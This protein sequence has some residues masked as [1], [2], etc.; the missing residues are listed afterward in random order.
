VP[1]VVLLGRQPLVAHELARG[2]S[3]ALLRRQFPRPGHELEGDHVGIGVLVG[4]VFGQH[5][6][7]HDEQLARYIVMLHSIH[8]F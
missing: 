7:G 3:T 4:G 6:P 1:E 2:Q 5:M 8:I